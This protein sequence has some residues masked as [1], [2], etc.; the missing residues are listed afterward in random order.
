VIGQGVFG[1]VPAAATSGGSFTFELVTAPGVPDPAV[2]VP[3][4]AR[5]GMS[6]AAP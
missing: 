1:K 6:I 2:L 4:F 3:L 5:R